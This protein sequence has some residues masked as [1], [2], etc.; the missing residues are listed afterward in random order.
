MADQDLVRLG[1]RSALWVQ[2]VHLEFF[3]RR[4]IQVLLAIPGNRL[5]D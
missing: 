2:S 1:L 5:R 4:C 3:I